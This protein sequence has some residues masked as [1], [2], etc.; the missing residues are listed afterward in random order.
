VSS[1]LV[2]F[3]C[4]DISYRYESHLF[5]LERLHLNL[6]RFKVTC[7][8][9]AS[10]LDRNLVRWLQQ[11]W[12]EVAVHCYDHGDPPELERD[13]KEERTRKALS[14]LSPLLP[15]EFGY[16]APGFQ[17]TGTSYPLLRT[18]GFWYIAHETRI[19]PLRN[20]YFRRLPLI[21]SHIYEDVG[22]DL[23]PNHEFA[24]ISEGFGLNHYARQVQGGFDQSRFGQPVPIHAG[25]L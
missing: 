20:R 18:I 6:P 1:Q 21:N 2:Y 25:R 22:R 23:R 11:D 14:V 15:V 9:I 24:F 16:R 12:I 7:F 8:V 5:E 3:T 4:D 19:Q 13:D 10:G 17:V